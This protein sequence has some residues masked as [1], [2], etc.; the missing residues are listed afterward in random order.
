MWIP[1]EPIAI[2]IIHSTVKQAPISIG[3]IFVGIS[4]SCSSTHPIRPIASENWDFGNREPIGLGDMS[5]AD[6]AI[7]GTAEGDQAIQS[8]R[9]QMASIDIGYYQ[10]GMND[11]LLRPIAISLTV[12]TNTTAQILQTHSMCGVLLFT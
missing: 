8:T 2:G 1:A 3:P 12:K 5:E 10:I 7:P 6:G 9:T 4:L 11:N